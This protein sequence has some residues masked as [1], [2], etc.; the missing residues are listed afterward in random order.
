M[1]GPILN[2]EPLPRRLETLTLVKQPSLKLY[3]TPLHETHRTPK[4]P[5]KG[6]CILNLNPRPLIKPKPE[7][8][9]LNPKPLTLIPKPWTLN[10]KV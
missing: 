7:S 9:I 8:Q 4:E 6:S 2:P 10:P 5:S 3:T 1:Y